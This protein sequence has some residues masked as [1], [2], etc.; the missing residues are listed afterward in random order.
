MQSL[1]P[2][3]SPNL[4]SLLL[5]S[6]AIG[7]LVSSLITLAG[8]YFE[9]R[10]RQKELLLAKSI[11]LAELHNGMLKAAAEH[12]GKTVSMYPYIVQTRWFHS[13]LQLLLSKGKLSG[14]LERQYGPYFN[15][16]T[17]ED[18]VDGL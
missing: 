15:S 10:A 2:M 12:S 6:A 13:Q 8:Q 18:K 11:E 5:G 17:S 1:I 7:A 16:P 14:E 9:R 3:T 4:I